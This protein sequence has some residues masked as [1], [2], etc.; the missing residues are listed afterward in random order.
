MSIYYS[1]IPANRCFYITRKIVLEDECNVIAFQWSNAQK[2]NYII[3][4]YISQKIVLILK[5]FCSDRLFKGHK[6]FRL[7]CPVL[8]SF[9]SVEQ[10]YDKNIFIK[11]SGWL[12]TDYNYRN[13]EIPPDENAESEH[14]RNRRGHKNCLNIERVSG[15]LPTGPHFFFALAF[16][17]G[18]DIL[19]CRS[20]SS[21]KW[22]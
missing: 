9:D 4:H 10:T 14:P 7:L 8:R 5:Y 15:I 13:P 20:H 3:Y 17:E 1:Y 18:T 21:E 22:N 6:H 11:V 12:L 19:E 2:H 16:C